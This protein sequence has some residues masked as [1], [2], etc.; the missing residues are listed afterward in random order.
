MKKIMK[1][2]YMFI[3]IILVVTCGFIIISNLSQK[4][5]LQKEIKAVSKKDLLTDQ[6]D[7]E[8]TTTGDYAYVEEVI[9]NYYKELSTSVKII[10]N[11]L[12]DEA[13]IKI[14]SVENI[15]KDGPIFSNSN[16][17]LTTTR[18]NL[19]NAMKTIINLCD[20]KN[21]KELINKKE[22]NKHT[23]NLYL[24]IMYNEKDLE[25]LSKTKDDMQVINDDLNLFLDK[26]ET[27]INMLKDNSKNWY[28]KDNQLYFKKDNLV[29]EYNSLYDDLN[30][31]VKEKFTS[32]E[33]TPSLKQTSV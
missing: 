7:I 28:V 19:D 2:I 23:Y 14:L 18:E 4:D 15:K 12:S 32:E 6:Y 13:L 24:E 22:V 33:N 29:K 25:V 8:I 5:I 1:Y 16:D 10:N 9:K 21:V 31:Y 30:K 11:Y 26:V 3:S 20:K 27:M 17:L